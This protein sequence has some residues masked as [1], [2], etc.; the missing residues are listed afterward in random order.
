[1]IFQCIVH[2]LE[3]VPQTEPLICKDTIKKKQQTPQL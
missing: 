3:S 1:M 2:V